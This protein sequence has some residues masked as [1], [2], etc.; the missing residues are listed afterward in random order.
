MISSAFH[1]WV[2]EHRPTGHVLDVGCGL[3]LHGMWGLDCKQLSLRDVAANADA[4]PLRHGS[5]DGVV[6]VQVLSYTTSDPVAI[7]R[8]IHRILRPG[9]VL[10]LTAPRWKWSPWRW[11]RLLLA[12]GFVHVS[13]VLPPRRLWSYRC[14]TAQ[15][16]DLPVGRD[17][18]DVHHR[19]RWV[20]TKPAA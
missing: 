13:V 1:E 20:P 18:D 2:E 8:E 4:I 11:D 3:R 17:W 12:M 19:S 9:G 15:R 14:W 16:G 5:V 10:L 6:C 7:L